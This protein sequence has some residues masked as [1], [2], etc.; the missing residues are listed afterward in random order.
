VQR[1]VAGREQVL[2]GTIFMG[3]DLAR[4]LQQELDGRAQRC[5]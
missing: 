3:F 2:P 1:A 4:W 5:A